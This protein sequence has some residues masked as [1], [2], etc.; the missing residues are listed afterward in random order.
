MIS[1]P[2]F[3]F[4]KGK[5]LLEKDSMYHHIIISEDAG[6]RYMKFGNRIVQSAVD[7]EDPVALKV[8][9]TK[10][11]P[12]GLIFK[13]NCMN[14]LIVGLGGG[15]LPRL[16]NDYCP[17]IKM[18]VVEIDPVVVEMAKRYFFVE[19]NPRY[20]IM[21]MDGRVFIKRSK[22]KY[23]IIIL[24][25]YN[26]DSIPFHMTTV[27]FL[28]E[29]KE[30]LSGD[31]VIITNLWS[32]DVQLY[33]SMVKTYEQVFDYLYRFQVWGKNNIILA[34]CDRE[35]DPYALVQRAALLQ[36]AVH[37]PYDF[38]GKASHLDR[39]TLDTSK[40]PILTDDYAPVDWLQHKGK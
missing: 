16:I 25:A 19:E 17:E 34:A 13:S 10:Y 31:G 9:Y 15:A 1:F 29:A 3:T 21:V 4:A 22:K 40:A 20:E 35:F 5:I 7:I 24:D 28:Q 6:V 30:R 2:M 36:G 26:S 23:D 8:E 32:S 12:L 14:M 33:I 37:F 38:A 11:M 18:D 39:R 27:E